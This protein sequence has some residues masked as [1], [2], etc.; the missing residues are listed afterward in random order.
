LPT[1]FFCWNLTLHQHTTVDEAAAATGFSRELCQAVIEQYFPKWKGYIEHKVDNDKYHRVTPTDRWFRGARKNRW[2]YHDLE[3]VFAAYGV[4]LEEGVPAPAGMAALHEISVRCPGCDKTFRATMPS[5]TA[6]KTLRC[7]SC[8]RQV[9]ARNLKGYVYVLVHPAMPRH[10]K[11]GRTAGQVAQRAKEDVEQR[12]AGLNRPTGVPGPFVI[13]AIFASHTPEEHES[14][15]H[16]RL[17]KISKRIEGR[18]FFEV[19]P[20]EAVRT[21]QEVVGTGPIDPCDGSLN[22]TLVDGRPAAGVGAE[23]GQH[24]DTNFVALDPDVREAFPTGRAVNDALR[25]VMELRKIGCS[26]V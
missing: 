10:V 11:V 8:G 23:A 19:E 1:W 2:G 20:E 14:E 26:D 12:V 9:I 24:A 25:L 6:A 17:Q 16:T 4:P 22:L 5:I 15:I 3:A 13:K 21:A 7:S 18:E